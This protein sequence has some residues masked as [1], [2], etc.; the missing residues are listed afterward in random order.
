MLLGYY[1]KASW[2]S[3]IANRFFVF[4]W[5]KSFLKIRK[6]YLVSN[7]VSCYFMKV[8]GIL[9]LLGVPWTASW[10][11]VIASLYTIELFVFIIVSWYSI[12]TAWCSIKPFAIPWSF[13]VLHWCFLVF[14]S[15]QYSLRVRS[16]LRFAGFSTTQKRSDSCLSLVFFLSIRFGLQGFSTIT[17]WE[18][19]TYLK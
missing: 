8:R 12:K 10:C 6:S 4:V 19:W 5:H 2:C 18:P 9:K 13:S 17:F 16:S 7:R 3:I 11:S 1:I 15:N 14:S